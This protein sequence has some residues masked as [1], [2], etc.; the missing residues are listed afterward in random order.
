MKLSLKQLR[1]FRVIVEQGSLRLAAEQLH[2]TQP[3]LSRQL[4][5]LE[6]TLGAELFERTGKRLHLTPTGD[7]LYEQ[8]AELLIQAAAVEAKV[9]AFASGDIGELKIGLTDDF[10]YAPLYQDILKFMGGHSEIQVETTLAITTDLMRLL[11]KNDLDL[12]LVNL[13]VE[14]DRAR[15]A[16]IETPPTRLVLVTPKDHPLAVRQSIAVEELDGLPLILMSETASSPFA[17]LYRNLFAEAE[18]T[19]ARGPSTDS[20]ALQLQMVRFGIGLGLFTEQSF[21]TG[22]EDLVA[23]PIDDPKAI[24]RHGLIYDRYRQPPSLK[25]LLASLNL[26]SDEEGAA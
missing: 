16:L 12:V 18:I 5:Q 22:Q 1:H 20:A 4:K 3:P 19:P 10:L 17:Q 21:A 26:P 13:P 25:R 2:L 14:L 11:D 6:E 23:I 24:L 15:F 8:S 9:R 7:Y